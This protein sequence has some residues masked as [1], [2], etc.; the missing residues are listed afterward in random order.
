MLGPV[1]DNF[2][3]QDNLLPKYH[4]KIG[5]DV[6][7]ITSRYIYD[8]KGKIT[9]DKRASY[10]NEN[11][12]KV[13]RL[14][15]RNDKA[16]SS[17]FKRFVNFY[18]TLERENPDIIFVHGCQFMDL[19]EIVRYIRVNPDKKMYIDNHADFSNSASNFLSKNI[20]HKI[21]WRY[22]ARLAEPYTE[23]FYGVLPARVD[24]LEEVYKLPEKKIELLVMG[25]DDERVK[26]TKQA[27]KESKI[28][29]KYGINRDNFLIV[30]GGKID[31]NKSQTLLLMEAINSINNPE[32]RLLVFGSIAPEY[33]DKFT[34]L[35]SDNVKYAGWIEPQDTY[36]YFNEADLVCFPGLHS[37]FW[38][39]VVGL[40]KPCVFKYI[41][42]F[43]HIDLGG[44]C[45]FIY[46]DSVEEIISVINKIANNQRLYE[47][48]KKVAINKGMQ[49]FSYRAIAEKSITM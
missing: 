3:Y 45:K 43:T 17:K 14:G 24:F 31:C 47:H 25:V 32:I 8:T 37:V 29:Q 13:I 19:K 10:T 38:E 30:T 39:Q 48:M 2:T 18:E 33:K 15:I 26:K 41:E 20:L 35:L 34:G 42:G 11:N 49:T 1:T 16:L 40:G 22:L 46:E 12:I 6:S 5:Y 9:M 28:R 4:K 21:I 44:N 36:M 23:K 27:Q 7:I